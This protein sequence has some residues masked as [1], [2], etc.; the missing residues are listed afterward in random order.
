MNQ[1]LYQIESQTAYMLIITRI[2]NIEDAGDDFVTEDELNEVLGISS[3]EDV[4]LNLNGRA[5]LRRA[6]IIAALNELRNKC[7]EAGKR[8]ILI[9]DDDLMD[10]FLSTGNPVSEFVAGLR[11]VGNRLFLH[12]ITKIKPKKSHVTSL[13]YC[14]QRTFNSHSGGMIIDIKYAAHNVPKTIELCKLLMAWDDIIFG[15][16]SD[17]NI[18]CM[19]QIWDNPTIF[20]KK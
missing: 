7:I 1:N 8:T 9:K 10:M 16:I 5:T 19:K 15:D 4:M 11:R 13:A 2:R 14:V 20:E 17:E 6:N 12:D 18:D 3:D